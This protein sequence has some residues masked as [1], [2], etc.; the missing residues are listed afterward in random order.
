MTVILGAMDGEITAIRENMDTARAVTWRSYQITTGT[1]AGEPV[2]LCRTGVG[3]TL[4]ALVCQHLIEAYR[5]DRVIFT[6]VAGSLRGD[7]EIGDT[8]IARDSIQHD[9]DATPLGMAP[10]EIPYSGYRVIPCDPDLVAIAARVE[11][12]GG[13][14]RIGRI[15]TG[16]QFMTDPA[17]R[18]ELRDRFGG[19]CVEMEGASVALVCAVNETPCVLIRTISDHADGTVD[20]QRALSMA[21]TNSWCYVAS[22]LSSL[23]GDDS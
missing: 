2:V 4:S 21:S 3:K 13:T 8:I 12:A 11:P 1:I 16:D 15:L 18:R 17:R 5:P 6:G 10:G 7:L 9:M 20:F 22:I 19:D 14:V 23:K